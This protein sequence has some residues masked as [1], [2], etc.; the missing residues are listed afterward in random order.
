VVAVVVTE[1]V[2]E[3]VAEEDAEDVAEDDAVLDAELDAVLDAEVDTVVVTDVRSQC[4]SPYSPC[5]KA[6]SARF[7]ANAALVQRTLSRRK[8]P[9]MQDTLLRS[10]KL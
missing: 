5:T 10:A 8:P 1:D 3:D 7:S 2:A 9:I 6:T 4:S